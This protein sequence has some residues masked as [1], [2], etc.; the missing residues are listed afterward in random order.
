MDSFWAYSSASDRESEP[1]STAG[2]HYFII[3]VRKCQSN[4]ANEI[5]FLFNLLESLDILEVAGL[6]VHYRFSLDR[7]QKLFRQIFSSTSNTL[8]YVS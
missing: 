3:P 8:K 7:V 4:S 1:T 2:G 6:I 5:Y